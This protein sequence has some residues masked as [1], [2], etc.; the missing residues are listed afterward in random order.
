MRILNLISA[1][2]TIFMLACQ[3]VSGQK[4]PDKFPTGQGKIITE[5][6]FDKLKY[7]AQQKLE[8]QNYRT[9]T[10]EEIFSGSKKVPDEIQVTVYESARPTGMRV[11][12][13]TKTSVGGI[14]KTGFMMI[15]DDRYR[16]DMNGEW[17]LDP[18]AG[19]GGGVGMGSGTKQI[20]Q[21]YR[22]IGKSILEGKRVLVYE[23]SGKRQSY[24]RKQFT[25]VNEQTRY[26]FSVDGRLLRQEG[27]EDY[28]ELNLRVKK[29][30]INTYNANIKI[31]APTVKRKS[32]S[33]KKANIVLL[34]GEY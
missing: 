2:I 24:F 25:E 9:R 32:V 10:V 19:Y 27:T 5:A 11:V 33:I 14:A 26:W 31:Q 16:I 34:K 22:F 28:A 18:R 12:T 4:M 30:V 13:E 17:I 1:V 7:K 20:P 15:D 21:V 23:V 3:I 6:E 29:L 8:S